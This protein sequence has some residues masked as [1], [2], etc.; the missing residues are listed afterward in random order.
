MQG[1]A[2]NDTKV[3]TLAGGG[4]TASTDAH[5]ARC[6]SV[7]LG[8]FPDLLAQGLRNV[9]RDDPSLHLLGANFDNGEF[10]CAIA[11]DRLRTA[12]VDEPAG[13]PLSSCLA[14]TDPP[15]NLLASGMNGSTPDNGVANCMPK[16]AVVAEAAVCSAL[17]S[18]RSAWPQT[19][20]LV[21]AHDPRRA[22]GMLLLSERVTCLADN[23]PAR[24]LLAAVHLVASGGRL[25]ASKD[26]QRVEPHH[27]EDIP[28]LTHR[29]MEVLRGVSVGWKAGQIALALEISIRT[30]EKHMVA[31]RRK[32]RVTSAR[33][34]V[35]LPVPSRKTQHVAER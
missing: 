29:E 13:P 25:F 35:G 3:T 30:V 11:R 23:V 18:A 10:K 5:A 17:E 7:V 9:L 22:F 26:G 12:I 4:S 34:L 15:V 1:R 2:L 32:L 16:V 8:R 27:A 19:R 33:D 28:P 20:V 24:D 14:P 31:I 21:L 6:V